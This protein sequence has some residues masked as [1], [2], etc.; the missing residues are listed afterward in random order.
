MTILYHLNQILHNQS[1]TIGFT[2]S[3]TWFQRMNRNPVQDLTDNHTPL[4]S[5]YIAGIPDYFR[6][7]PTELHITHI[8]HNHQKSRDS[9]LPRCHHDTLHHNR[10]STQNSY[11]QLHTSYHTRY[12]TY[13]PFLSQFLI[14]VMK[15]TILLKGMRIL[16]LKIQL[17]LQEKVYLLILILKLLLFPFFRYKMIWHRNIWILLNSQQEHLST[18]PTST[19]WL[20]WMK[21][22]FSWKNGIFIRK[23]SSSIQHWYHWINYQMLSLI[24]LTTRIVNSKDMKDS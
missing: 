23:E 9:L 17:W 2:H 16:F 10:L 4:R 22:L 3:F 15:N 19:G 6:H 7:H 13:S 18:I 11:H 14:V 20:N 21:E 1:L 12:R 8:P 5:D 24:Y